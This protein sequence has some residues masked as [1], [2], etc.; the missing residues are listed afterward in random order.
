M[1]TEALL[2][3]VLV[4]KF[5]DHLPLYRQ[6]AIFARHE[7]ELNRSTLCDGVGWV[8]TDPMELGRDGRR[9]WP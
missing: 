3:Q 4:A 9:N 5:C 1:A 8:W 7:I 2:A 6:A